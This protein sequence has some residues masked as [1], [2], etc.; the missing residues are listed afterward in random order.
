MAQPLGSSTSRAPNGAMRCPRTLPD[1]FRGG[2]GATTLQPRT[3]RNARALHL[4]GM[5][6]PTLH[7]RGEIRERTGWPSFMGPLPEHVGTKRISS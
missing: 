7:R 6:S 4:R 5:S 2:D 1:P 3:G